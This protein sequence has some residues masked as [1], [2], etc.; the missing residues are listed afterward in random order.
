MNKLID[1]ICDYVCLAYIKKP[2]S[3]SERDPITYIICKGMVFRGLGKRSYI[4]IGMASYYFI[5][6]FQIV[7]ESKYACIV[8]YLL[9]I[10][11]DFYR[12]IYMV[13]G[14][15]LLSYVILLLL[16]GSSYNF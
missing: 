2:E 10:Q 1:F 6:T 12:K 11:F 5:P 16:K 4:W 7:M 3:G 9:M 8:L 15:L 13:H 14:Q